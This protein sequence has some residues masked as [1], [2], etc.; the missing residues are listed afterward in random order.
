MVYRCDK[1]AM[2][3]H[4]SASH[5]IS[6]SVLAAQKTCKSYIELERQYILHEVPLQ[7]ISLQNLLLHCLWLATVSDENQ[8][9]FLKPAKHIINIYILKCGKKNNF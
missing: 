6:L 9:C 1:K 2:M 7:A 8:A 5:L 3:P 4:N